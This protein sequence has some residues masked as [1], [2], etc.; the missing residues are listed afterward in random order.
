[1]GDIEYEKDIVSKMILI[2]CRH[3]H[4][5]QKGLCESCLDLE[6]YALN[7]LSKCSFGENK[8]ACKVCKVHCYRPEMRKQIKIV[9]SY[10]GPRML[11]YY[12]GDFL[13]HLAKTTFRK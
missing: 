6:D 4:R 13:K 10:S 9:M 12:P 11:F 1:M 2:Y 7:R 3:K 5:T 8:P